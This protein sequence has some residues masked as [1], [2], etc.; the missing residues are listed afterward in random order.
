M[1]VEQVNVAYARTCADSADGNPGTLVAAVSG[2]SYLELTGSDADGCAV[3]LSETGATRG[4]RIEAVVVA[5]AGGTLNFADTTGVQETGAGC[6]L[7]LYGT[8]TF[9]YI[10]DRHVLVACTPSN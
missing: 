9:R 8:A 10:G 6:S 3:T 4:Q 5:T 1:F 2:A 7:S